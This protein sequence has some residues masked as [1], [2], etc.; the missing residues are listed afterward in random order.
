MRNHQRP[1]RVMQI[2]TRLIWGGAQ[3]VTVLIVKRLLAEGFQVVF[4]HGPGD[5]S[6]L[7]KLPQNEP[8]LELLPVPEFRRRILPFWDILAFWRIYRYLKKNRVDLVH[9]HTSKAGIIGR[10]AAYLAGVPVIIHSPRG[11][12]YHETYF[13][14]AVLR[15]FA[16]LEGLTAR[17]TRKIVTLCESEKKDYI[18][19]GIA[20]KEKF[21]TIYSGV[22]VARYVDIP[23]DT[24]KKKKELGIP[25]KR[26]V[27]GYVARMTPEKGHLFCLEA[28]QRVLKEFPDAVLVFAGGG[29]LEAQVKEAIGRLGISS[30]VVMTGFRKDVSEV[31]RTFDFAIQP[32]LWDGLPRAMVECMLAEKAVVATSVG[33]IPEIIHD[34]KTGYLIPEKDEKAMAEGM[35]KLL[36]DPGLAKTMGFNARKRMEEV[37]NIDVSVEKLFTLY[38]ALIQEGTEDSTAC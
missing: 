1:Y 5:D 22:E 36:R 34:G 30:S 12:I 38:E 10:W 25:E 14:A 26:P 7:Q 28:F 6:L 23:V 15:F 19:Y 29:P 13:K 2:I 20:P 3:E 18:R 27:I 31:V 9:T 37:F 16:W 11:S 32:S 17:F 4:A 35:L 21:T 33:G 8:G 24:A